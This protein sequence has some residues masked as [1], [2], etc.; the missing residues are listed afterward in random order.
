MQTIVI[1]KLTTWEAAFGI[2]VVFLSV[3]AVST[4]VFNYSCSPA[5]GS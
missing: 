1:Y 4:I 2:T 5:A 3:L